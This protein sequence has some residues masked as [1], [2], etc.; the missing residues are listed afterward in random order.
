MAHYKSKE[1]LYA[2]VDR[3]FRAEFPTAPQQLSADAPEHEQWR[4]DWLLYRDIALSSE[5]NRI[6][7]ELYP[8]API[9]IDPD[10]PEHQRWVQVWNEIYANVKSFEPQPPFGVYSMDQTELRADVLR[11]VLLY[12]SEIRPDLHQD[13]RWTVES[14]M[15]NYREAW[16]SGS[17]IA[18]RYWE[19]P[20]VELVSNEDPT[21]K[22]RLGIIIRADGYNPSGTPSVEI[23]NP[24]TAP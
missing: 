6:Y 20:V 10:N 7:W 13:V 11:S 1:E 14:W 17:L 23:D 15:D 4:R 2:E 21:H 16:E 22:V 12:L 9:Q 19:P 5:A 18:H 3:N 8:E 24:V